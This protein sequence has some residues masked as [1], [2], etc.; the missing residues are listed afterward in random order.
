MQLQN[1]NTQ[2][3][4]FMTKFTSKINKK[5]NKY[6]TTELRGLIKQ[7]KI[8]LEEF[9]QSPIYED[10]I[11]LSLNKS[12]SFG[13]V[14]CYKLYQN[15]LLKEIIDHTA[16]LPKKIKQEIEALLQDPNLPL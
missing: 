13:V 7:Y 6:I 8:P 4:Y 15:D 3:N 5:S 1:T 2:D 9:V 12:D 10:Y 16:K 11:L 14:N